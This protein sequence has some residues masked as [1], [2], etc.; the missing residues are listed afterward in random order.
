[1]IPDPGALSA[2]IEGKGV[3][4]K[5]GS[6]GQVKVVYTITPEGTGRR[7]WSTPT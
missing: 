6:R 5:G 4:R 7:W 1:M 2:T 3:D